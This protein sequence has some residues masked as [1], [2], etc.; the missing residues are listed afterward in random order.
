MKKIISNTK[1]IIFGITSYAIYLASGKRVLTR[2]ARKYRRMAI[3]KNDKRI[4][5]MQRVLDE[6]HSRLRG[7]TASDRTVKAESADRDM[8]LEAEIAKTYLE[9]CKCR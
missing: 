1:E 4:K 8:L 5:E 7:W 9:L 6:E 2:T 3:E